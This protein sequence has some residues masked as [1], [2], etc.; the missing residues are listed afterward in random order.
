MLLCVAFVASCGSLDINDLDKGEQE[1]FLVDRASA[2]NT[3][4]GAFVLARRAITTNSSWIMYGDVRSGMVTINGPERTLFDHQKLNS[5]TELFQSLNDWKRYYDAIHQCDFVVEE[6]PLI[7]SLITEDEIALIV[8]Q[9]KYLRSL[10][11]FNLV[12]IWGDVPLVSTTSQTRIPRTDQT[13]VLDYII[14]D[15]EQVEEVLPAQYLDENGELDLEKQ[16]KRPTKGAVYALLAHV[17]AWKGDKP[18]ALQA[19]NNLIELDLYNLVPGRRLNTVLDGGFTEENIFGFFE[20]TNINDDFEMG[21]FENLFQK[22]IFFQGVV[23]NRLEPLAFEKLDALYES[24]DLRRSEYFSV[25]DVSFEVRMT[26]ESNGSSLF[27]LADILLLGAEASAESD[28]T[29][30]RNFLNQ[31][32]NRA[33]IADFD[34]SDEELPAAILD[35]RRRELYAEGHDFFDLM[36][37]GKV[38]EKVRNITPSHIRDGIV[39]WPLAQVAFANNPSI[40]QNP[41]WIQP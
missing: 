29:A 13:M 2:S 17:Q 35:E 40:Q 11:Y 9:A 8:A 27:R 14:A 10:L 28:P 38:A 15:L 33:G 24:S 39:Y 18:A 1:A 34:G 30:S 20:S 36:R 25:N 12:R 7:E 23:S 3:L 32:R 41:F 31:V 4:G 22:S 6:V 26:K 37:F 19:V 16:Y 5:N 21:E